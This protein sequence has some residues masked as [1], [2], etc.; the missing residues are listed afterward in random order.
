MA[1][2][3]PDGITMR[4]KVIA[5]LI[6]DAITSAIL[7]YRVITNLGYISRHLHLYQPYIVIYYLFIIMTSFIYLRIRKI[8]WKYI[9]YGALFGCVSGII[10][11]IS[12]YL[13]GIFTYTPHM[14]LK[15][16]EYLHT[17][18]FSEFMGILIFPILLWDLWDYALLNSIILYAI[19]KFILHVKK[20]RL[21]A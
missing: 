7:I 20:R 3:K 19:L 17:H 8:S 6:S 12:W 11:S 10:A 18:F 4:T 2:Q 14:K 15:Y 16:L 1:T 9:P 5:L 13:I 21:H